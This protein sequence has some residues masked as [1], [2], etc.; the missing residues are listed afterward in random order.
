MR[1]FFLECKCSKNLKSVASKLMRVGLN[2]RTLKLLLFCFLH[3]HTVLSWFIFF[4]CMSE[5]NLTPF[6]KIIAFKSI[7]IFIFGRF[8]LHGSKMWT[9]LLWVS[10]GKHRHWNQSNNWKINKWLHIN[11]GS[12]GKTVLLS[13]LEISKF[14]YYRNHIKKILCLL[15]G[16]KFGL[17]VI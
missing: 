5:D 15:W 2:V 10:D 8:L 9:Q 17:F 4:H 13:S 7:K 16:Y 12:K 3:K 6:L 1:I 14:E 11:L